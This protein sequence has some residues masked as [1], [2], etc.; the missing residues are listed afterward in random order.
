MM[1]KK[2]LLKLFLFSL[3]FLGLLL[4]GILLPCTPRSSE[5]LL[6]AQLEKD[7]RLEKTPGKRIILV[8]GSNLSFGINSRMLSD[9]LKWPVINAGVHAKIGLQYMMDHSIPFIHEGDVIV[10]VPEYNQ[11]FGNF[12]YGG[13][14][15]LRTLLDVDASQLSLLNFQQIKSLLPLLPEYAFSKFRQREYFYHFDKDNVY[16]KTAF[17]EQGDVYKHWTQASEKVLPDKVL[18]GTFN[19]QLIEAMIEYKQKIEARGGRLLLGF[20]CYQASSFDV[21][22]KGIAAVEQQLQAG[23]FQLLGNA[24]K[25]RMADSLFF[26][27]TYHLNKQGVDWRTLTLAEDLKQN[28]K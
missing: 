20:P 11:F 15:L 19:Q 14:E 24:L 23:G 26:N 5:S 13:E 12:A 8:G 3:V 27:T 4:L 22:Q 7:K 10:L 16:L 1:M 6:F 25:Y 17:N 28:L 2:F 18:E 9:Q 21:N